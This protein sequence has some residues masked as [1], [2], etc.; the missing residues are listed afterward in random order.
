MCNQ[1]FREN[2]KLLTPPIIT[3]STYSCRTRCKVDELSE[4]CP[5]QFLV[6]RK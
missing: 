3:H 5:I 2:T 6:S 4:L 1:E